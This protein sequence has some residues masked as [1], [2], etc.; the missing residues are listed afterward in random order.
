MVEASVQD[1]ALLSKL[2]EIVSMLGDE[3]EQAKFQK[4][5]PT[6]CPYAEHYAKDLDFCITQVSDCVVISAEASPAG[7]INL[8]NHC[9]GASVRLLQL[10][11]LCR[12]FITKGLI[13]HTR[14]QF[15]G[16]G[17][18]KAVNSEKN[19]SAFRNAAFNRGTPFIE[20]DDS[21]VQYASDM[22]DKCTK[23]MFNRLTKFDGEYCDISL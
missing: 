4:Y 17:Y 23:V 21:V 9:F 20:L 1:P 8:I 14:N 10:G 6:C 16:P 11:V 5:G 7:F 12:G 19:V 22:T 3:T 15:V 18:L 2:L 13:Y